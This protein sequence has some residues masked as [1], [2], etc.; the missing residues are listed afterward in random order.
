MAPSSKQV[1]RDV[2]VRSAD[3]REVVREV[4]YRG[5]DQD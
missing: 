5:C 4:A 3:L 1:L 2:S